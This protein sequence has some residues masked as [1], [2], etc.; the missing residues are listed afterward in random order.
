[1]ACEKSGAWCTITYSVWQ[2]LLLWR[3][4]C[5][6]QMLPHVKQGV[7]S[8]TLPIHVHSAHQVHAVMPPS[9][10]PN[11]S[12]SADN[13]LLIAQAL[14]PP[15][16]EQQRPAPA[17]TLTPTPTR[18]A[19]PPARPARPTQCASQGQVR[20]FLPSPLLIPRNAFA[21]RAIISPKEPQASH[22][23]PAPPGPTVPE[24]SRLL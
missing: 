19:A 16:R 9:T 17:A 1:V 24:G 20:A 10:N 14:S 4:F 2:P 15:L 13:C 23:R 11:A 5:E 21:K 18:R 6:A 8:I 12:S 22:A 7:I 3:R